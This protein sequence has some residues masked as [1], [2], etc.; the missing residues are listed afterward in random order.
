MADTVA[1]IFISFKILL[2][3]LL[4]TK[5]KDKNDGSEFFLAS[6]V[7]HARKKLTT[8]VV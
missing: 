2:F 7:G 1:L 4:M 8:I 5:M 3:L 6:E